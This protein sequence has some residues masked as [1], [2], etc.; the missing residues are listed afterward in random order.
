MLLGSVIAMLFIVPAFPQGW[1]SVL[2]NLCLSAVLVCA[3]LSMDRSTNRMVVFALVL[4]AIEW[5]A[6]FLDLTSLVALSRL[7][8]LIFF[9][10]VVVRLIAQI[11]RTRIVTGRV[12]TEAINGYLLLGI[13]FSVIV[14]ILTA[15]DADAITSGTAT[16]FGR[17]AL[18]LNE[19]IYFG[20]ITFTTLGY[21]DIVPKTP[22][23][24]SL[25]IAASV[26]GQIY[27][28]VIIAMLVGKVLSRPR[29][30]A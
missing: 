6:F 1:H 10:W 27:L 18:T 15:L 28:T 19:A 8:I 5:I 2:Y 21:G 7:L 23:A 22:I 3:A 11:A 20:F 24:R 12:I 26:T 29:G 14:M 25:A 16:P 9:I 17:A 4:T 30:E 13:V